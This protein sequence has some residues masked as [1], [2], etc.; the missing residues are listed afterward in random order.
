MNRTWWP[1]Y[2]HYLNICKSSELSTFYYRFR[3]Y[4][5]NVDVKKWYFCKDIFLFRNNIKNNL[6]LFW[7]IFDIYF[8]SWRIWPPFVKSL[9]CNLTDETSFFILFYS[10]VQHVLHSYAKKAR[11]MYGRDLQ[12]EGITAIIKP[13][14]RL[15]AGN[16]RLFRN[17]VS[18]LRKRR[19]HPMGAV[20]SLCIRGYQ[21]RSHIWKLE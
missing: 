9:C 2:A 10:T 19:S 6:I 18:S 17:Q 5:C 21:R 15:P 3:I 14:R 11:R 1:S 13:A 7:N 8:W 12:R 16:G 4:V 20:I